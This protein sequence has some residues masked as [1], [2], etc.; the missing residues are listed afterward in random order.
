MAHEVAIFEGVILRLMPEIFCSDAP[1]IPFR[2]FR[3]EETYFE[4]KGW[5]SPEDWN[6]SDLHC[7]IVESYDLYM[8]GK[9]PGWM[10]C[11]NPIK[12]AN[13]LF[14]NLDV[15][16]GGGNVIKR[17]RVSPFTGQFRIMENING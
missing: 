15:L 10:I 4:D 12:D 14:I 6:D 2:A 5:L 9:P 17:Y 7:Y 16:D 11:K 8:E 3:S 1:S 13:Y